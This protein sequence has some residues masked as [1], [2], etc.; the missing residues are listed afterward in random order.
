M[1]TYPLNQYSTRKGADYS[2]DQLSR[3]I[4]RGVMKHMQRVVP[5]FDD[6]STSEDSAADEQSVDLRAMLL[7]RF[8][9]PKSGN[10]DSRRS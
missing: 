2:I 6:A 9:A 5:Q 8:A 7:G 3:F 1:V 10:A 4:D